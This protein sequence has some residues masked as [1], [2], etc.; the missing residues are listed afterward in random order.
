MNRRIDL[1]IDSL[2][3]RFTVARARRDGSFVHGPLGSAELIEV[4][5]FAPRWSDRHVGGCLAPMP[6]IVRQVLV[7]VGDRVA[8]R[9]P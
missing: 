1:E 5:R 8:K 3:R 2:R 7:A 6:G 9:A 4:P